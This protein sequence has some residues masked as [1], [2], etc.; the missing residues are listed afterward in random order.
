MDKF[1]NINIHTYDLI[2][3]NLIKTTQTH[4]LYIP[5]ILVRKGKL[6][7]GE[8][9]EGEPQARTFRSDLVY[10]ALIVQKISLY[11]PIFYN[12]YNS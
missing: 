1:R 6:I 3:L 11:M 7:Q 12:F 9:F 2:T 4:F 5:K 10:L 8:K